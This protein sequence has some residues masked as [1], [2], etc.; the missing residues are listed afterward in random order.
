LTASIGKLGGQ[1]RTGTLSERR[2]L[3]MWIMGKWEQRSQ[4]R[5]EI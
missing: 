3:E 1:Q 5:E 2:E 4:E